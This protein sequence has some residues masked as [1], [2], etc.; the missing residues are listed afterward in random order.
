[1]E[2]DKSPRGKERKT[3]KYIVWKITPRTFEEN[4]KFVNK[5]DA[6]SFAE[7][8]N[9]TVRPG[10]RYEVTKEGETPVW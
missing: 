8:A 5:E 10:T 7:F 3:M 1:M 9:A 4:A 6:E 2:R